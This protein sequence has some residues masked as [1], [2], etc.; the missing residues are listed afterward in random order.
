MPRQARQTSP[1]GLDHVTVR[2]VDRQDIF[3]HDTDSGHFLQ[4]V[5]QANGCL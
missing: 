3:H 2:G 1:N 4:P 5:G